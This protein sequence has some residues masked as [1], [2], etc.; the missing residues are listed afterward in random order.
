MSFIYAV[1][2]TLPDEE[3][4]RAYRDWLTDGHVQAVLEGGA[5]AAAVTRLHHDPGDPPRIES[6]YVFAS[7]E[8]F[9]AYERD[10]APALRADGA[11]RFGSRPGVSFARWTGDL[12]QAWP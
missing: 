3:T 12:V 2:A 6:R 4:A 7:R 1:I 10:H 9:E 8:A 5:T 11:Q